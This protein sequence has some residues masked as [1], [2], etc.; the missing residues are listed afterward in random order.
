MQLDRRLLGWGVFFILLG[1]IPLLVK[2]G[3]LDPQLV[4][5]WPL[6]WPILLIGWGL[7]LLL[8]GTSLALVGGAVSAITFGVMGGGALATG[9]SGVPFGSGCGDADTGIAFPSQ[10]GEF[11]DRA[12]VDIEL[13]CGSLSVATLPGSSWT[14]E[15]MDRDASGPALV[16]GGGQLALES[17][18]EGE[19]FDAT[20]RV[21]WRV[22]LPSASLVTLGLTINAGEGDLVLNGRYSS[23]NLTVNAGSADLFLGGAQE[24]GDVNATVN[25]GRVLVAYPA[26][27]GSG[28]LALNAGSM[29]VCVAPDAALR[30]AWNGTLASHNLE[31][32][33]LEEVD[34]DTWA[35]GGFDVAQPHLEL[36]VNASAGAFKV[37]RD[38]TCG[39]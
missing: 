25:A 22:G 2:A 21:S 33:G 17:R 37:D 6:L 18:D 30:V 9:F 1:A 3:L 23:I 26:G 4:G 5:R 24:V 20:G 14:V 28:N 32:A 12:Q 39:G 11:G 19:P 38:G 10:S 16:S 27:D 29:E 7:G 35:T 15:G 36:N 13:S 34:D 31:A 8:R